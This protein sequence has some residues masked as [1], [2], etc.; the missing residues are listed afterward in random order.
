[1]AEE[2]KTRVGNHGKKYSDSIKKVQAGKRYTVDE[3]LVLMQ[4]L[5]FAKFDETV[6]VAFNLGVDPKH[7]DQMVRG[8]VVLPHGIG[9]TVRI[10][11]LAKGDKAKEAQTAGADHV[12][13]ED[14]IEKIQGGWMEFDKMIATPDMMVA[15]SKIGKILGPRGLMPNPKLGTVTFEV[16]R[17]VKEQKLGKI[18]YR[19]E[20]AGI[21]HVAIGKKSF[22]AQKLRENFVALANVL[23]KAKPPT[24]KGT[25]IKNITLSSTMSPGISVD[26][27]D[28]M[29]ITGNG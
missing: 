14:L 18:E 17:A 21:V 16:A 15:V 24:S 3:A 9:K 8:A 29:A 28:T 4:E 13:A 12:G 2:K 26:P 19:T 22:G 27:A 1:M 10:A 20:K 5:A 23:I 11:V 25:Y 7:A 6:D